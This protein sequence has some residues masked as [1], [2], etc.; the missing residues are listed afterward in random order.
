MQDGD[1]RIFTGGQDTPETMAAN[2]AYFE[3]QGA[4][5]EIEGE[6][7][8]AAEPAKTDEQPP[9][10]EP[11]KVSEPTDDQVDA[12]IAADLEKAGNDGTRKVSR[13]GKLKGKLAEESAR[14]AAA[15]TRRI[16]L[17]AEIASLRKSAEPAA[18]V[19][20]PAKTTASTEFSEAEPKEPTLEDFQDSPDPHAELIKAHGKWTREWAPWSYRKAN[21]DQ[22]Q[23]TAAKQR[24]QDTE[25]QQQETQRQ[26]ETRQ[27]RIVREIEEVKAVDPTFDVNKIPLNPALNAAL[28]SLPGGVKILKQLFDDPAKLQEL[29][30]ATKEQ[31]LYEGR[32]IATQQSYDMAI[33]LLGKYAASNTAQA[34]KPNGNGA[35]PPSAVQAPRE[36]QAEPSPARGRGTGPAV[37]IDDIPDVTQ[38]RDA[39]KLQMVG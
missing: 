15:E 18:A 25:R 7:I 12:E 28:S 35:S 20:A 2:K 1:S 22:Q 13:W 30:E 38:R 23:Q 11:G 29:S 33:F 32:A 31:Q 39:R 10:A 8:P 4:T 3:S 5:V 6:A 14:A 9:A 19:A 21:F 34:A 24:Q 17:E 16:E 27:A 26:N 37:K 36:V